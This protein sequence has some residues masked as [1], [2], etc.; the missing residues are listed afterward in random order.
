MFG[1]RGSGKSTLLRELFGKE[2]EPLWIDFLD[3][4][5]EF[6]YSNNPNLVL[7]R[8]L[9]DKPKWIIIDEIQKVPS[10]LDVAHL[11]IEKHRIK[12]AFTGSSSRKLRKGGAN[13][14]ANRVASFSLAPFSSIELKTKFNL[15]RALSIGLLPRFWSDESLTPEDIHRAL[16]SYVQTY[17][18]E[19]VAAEQ[20]V[21][22]L[23]PFRRFLICAAQSAGKVVNYA[24]L[25]RDSGV[26]H[27]QAERHFEI[28]VDTLIGQY[29]E[30]FDNSLR[31]RQTKKSKFYFFDTGVIR[32]LRDLLAE[33]LTPSTF[34]YGD[35]FESFVVNEFFKIS[36]ALEKRWKFSFLRTQNNL[37]IDLIL[38]KPR[39]APILIEIKSTNRIVDD[40]IQSL[41]KISSTLSHSEK[42]L[43][44]NDPLTKEIHGIR[45]LPWQ[46]G[47]QEIFELK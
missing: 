5:T 14:L 19:E 28:L 27:S 47:L 37:E 35:L 39:G 8:W 38:E 7:Q 43:L 21:R 45:C 6:E 12:F 30:P 17:L 18:K 13:L 40:H 33:A 20:L 3:Q 4:Q 22:N 46:D 32:A 9:I 31:K 29:L 34:E 26:T 25:E 2:P 1:P 16:Y 10:V 44:S 24:Q 23:A 15:T 42:Y 36:S 11:G 41:K